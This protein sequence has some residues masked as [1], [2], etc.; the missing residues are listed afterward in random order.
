MR[1]PYGN[2]VAN[3][4]A[5]A[6]LIRETSARLFHRSGCHVTFQADV[7]RPRAHRYDYD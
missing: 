3:I 5:I 7:A 6:G 4:A 2:D 1:S